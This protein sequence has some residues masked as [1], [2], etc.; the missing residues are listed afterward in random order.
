[1]KFLSRSLILIALLGG[2][3]SY[4]LT[5]PDVPP[6]RKVDSYGGIS[7]KDEKARL[8]AFAAEL[9]KEPHSQGYIMVYAGKR[10]RR[11]EAHARGQ[12]AR[13]YLLGNWVMHEKQVVAID[14]GHRESRATELFIVPP[15]GSPPPSEPTVDPNEVQIIGGRA[16]ERGA[17]L[18]RKTR[19]TTAC[20]RRLTHLSNR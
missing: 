17:A 1:M 13:A 5:N 16:G 20:P 11:G 18:S 7:F 14:G 4:A 12:R 19:L 15:G 10:A 8:D 6:N 2:T 3:A 9:K